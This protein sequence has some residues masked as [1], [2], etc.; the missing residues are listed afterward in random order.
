MIEIRN[1]TRKFKNNNLVKKTVEKV[2][3]GEKK[4]NI[5]VSIVIV[6]EK[7]IR[8]F[9]KRYRN[10]DK[11]TDV[12]SF[13]VSKNFITVQKE[14]GEIVICP[15]WIN[16]NKEGLKRVIIHGVLHLLGYDHKNDEDEIIMKKREDYYL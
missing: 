7:K 1:L 3:K 5:D 6:G 14:L 8:E 10:K 16:K 2:L 13:T 11:V 15:E 4:D 9:N 12:L